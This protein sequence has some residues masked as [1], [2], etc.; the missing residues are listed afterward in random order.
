[1]TLSQ[2]VAHRWVDGNQVY[3]TTDGFSIDLDKTLGAPDPRGWVLHRVTAKVDDAVA[4]Y[5]KVSFIP[6]AEFDVLY[7]TLAHYLGKIQ[8]R[9]FSVDL[10]TPAGQ[11]A[12]YL[13]V[14]G[15]DVDPGVAVLTSRKL[16]NV[17]ARKYQAGLDGFREYHRDKPQVDY[18]KVEDVLVDNVRIRRGIGLALY[19][20]TARWLSREGLALW[21]SSTQTD[22]AKAI[23]K[24]MQGRG[25]PV[26]QAHGRLHLKY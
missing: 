17:V 21:S 18:V 11:R 1:M 25:Y 3:Q 6:G 23:W 12:A 26:Y 24:A 22:A 20:Y 10:T 5:M 16:V 15:I 8:G 19:E 7:P 14:M 9:H 4:G 13:N 2:R